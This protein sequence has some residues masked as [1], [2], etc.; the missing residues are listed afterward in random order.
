MKESR[1]IWEFS[2]TRKLKQLNII[3]PITDIRNSYVTD[4]NIKEQY[5]QYDPLA[6]A[7]K[8]IEMII[9]NMGPYE[10]ITKEELYE[11]IFFLLNR[12]DRFSGAPLDRENQRKILDIIFEK[13]VLQHKKEGSKSEYVDYSKEIPE[14]KE[15]SC[16]LITNRNYDDENIVLFAEPETINFFFGMLDVKLEDQQIANHIILQRQ[17]ERKD[18]ER[19]LE[20]A[21]HELRLTRLYSIKLEE[22]IKQTKRNLAE[23]DWRV[24]IPKE[25]QDAKEHID[26]CMKEQS[27]LILK[28]D[29]FRY[30]LETGNETRIKQLNPLKK[31]LTQSHDKLLPLESK[32]N[33]AREVFIKEQWIQEL[34]RSRTSR[35]NIESDLFYNLLLVNYGQLIKNFDIFIPFFTGIEIPKQV[36]LDQIIELIQDR[37]TFDL[38]EDKDETNGKIKEIELIDLQKYPLELRNEVTSFLIDNL[39]DDGKPC[40][41][42]ILISKAIELKK[43]STFINY[44]RLLVQGRFAHDKFQ[45]RY[46]HDLISVTIV[47]DDFENEIYQGN[48]Y[49]IKLVDHVE[50]I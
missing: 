36:S 4:P 22:I 1:E 7:L 23:L 13:L 37:M 35:I 48:D 43:N 50:G 28:V 49:K 31:V 20:H 33:R 45:N 39:K 9:D 29:I 10:G 21:H 16:R 24:K 41:L 27:E 46:L 17:L 32:I 40:L 6:I 14:R 42:S 34:L 38:E 18:F 12:M 25:L 2:L 19:A 11:N 5:K 44:L 26:R 47:P 30:E 8:M 15:M 3:H